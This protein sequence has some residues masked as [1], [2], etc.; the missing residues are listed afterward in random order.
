[1]PDAHAKPQPSVPES[2]TLGPVA[3]AEPEPQAPPAARES[4][5]TTRREEAPSSDNE[6]E[7][8]TGTT[9]LESADS[10]IKEKPKLPSI[11]VTDE[12]R[13]SKNGA[14]RIYA[15]LLDYANKIEDPE[16]RAEV[17][18]K[19]QNGMGKATA[20]YESA[21][22]ETKSS[23]LAALQPVATVLAGAIS[24]AA[25]FA[26]GSSMAA[27]PSTPA[28]GTTA[29]SVSSIPA[30]TITSPAAGVAGRPPTAAFPTATTPVPYPISEPVRAAQIQGL[31]ELPLD[32]AM[33]F[34]NYNQLR[35]GDVIVHDYTTKGYIDAF[36]HDA[37]THNYKALTNPSQF[38]SGT[39]SEQKMSQWLT[40]WGGWRVGEKKRTISRLSGLSVISALNGAFF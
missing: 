32:D 36:R 30:A 3:A 22:P 28:T 1:M 6:E 24:A 13:N 29:P 4:A 16:R 15:K 27:A 9:G 25:G 35:G 5:G 20:A 23:G 31:V 8:E 11:P 39:I 34:V 33:K 21:P 18:A 26:A 38:P 2:P 14:A 37:S 12:M 17:L 40:D 10:Q 7:E 19:I